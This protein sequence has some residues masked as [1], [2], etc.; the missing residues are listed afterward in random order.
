MRTREL[1]LAATGRLLLLAACALAAPAVESASDDPLEPPDLSEYIRWGPIRARP[2][3]TVSNLGKDDNVFFATGSEPPKSDYRATVGGRLEGL[4]LFGDR[5]FLTFDERLNYTL[6][7][8]YGSTTTDPDGNKVPGQ[9]YLSQ[10]L[11]SRVTFPF[12]GWGVF[13][14]VD[15][16]QTETRPTSEFNGRVQQQIERA[17]MGFIVELGWRTYAEFERS[18][19]DWTYDERDRPD[20]AAKLNRLEQRNLLRVNYRLTGLTRLTFDTALVEYS[21]DDDTD[22]DSTQMQILPG[23][24]LGEGGRLSGSV[25]IGYSQFDLQDPAQEDFDST[26]GVASIRYRMGSGT[27]LRLDGGRDVGFAVFDE[28]TFY[29]NRFA[30][31]RATHYFNSLIGGTVAGY[32]GKLSYPQEM[33]FRIDTNREYELGVLFRALQT[34]GGKVVEYGLSWRRASRE[35]VTGD[36]PLPDPDLTQTRSVWGFTANAGF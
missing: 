3:L 6:F 29:L 31:A 5:A 2:R 17:G 26:V 33:G 27:T 7:H 8:K 19:S 32:Y 12:S 14:D 9:N 20:T 15:F 30:E 13:A 10:F 28:N 23:F 35:S 4:V 22:R 21:F 1:R 34:R 16:I 11:T 18:R 36:P 24:T 25:Q